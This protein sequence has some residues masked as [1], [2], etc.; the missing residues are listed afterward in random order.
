MCSRK[1]VGCHGL[2]FASTNSTYA[3]MFVAHHRWLGPVWPA[4]L[5]FRL[6]LAQ[7]LGV[8]SGIVAQLAGHAALDDL[9]WLAVL[10]LF[11]SKVD[12]LLAFGRWLYALV[13]DARELVC[14]AYDKLS[15]IH[16]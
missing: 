16:I 13:P 5:R 12:S 15:L 6:V 3:V 8:A 4:D 9:P 11:E 1:Q 10:E 14:A 2:V 7:R